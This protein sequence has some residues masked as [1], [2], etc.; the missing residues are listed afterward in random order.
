MI[1]YEAEAWETG[2]R[3][4]DE[5]GYDS[6]PHSRYGGNNPVQSEESRHTYHQASHAGDYYRDTN[7]TYNNNSNPNLRLGPRSQASHSNLSH[8]S[9]LLP[10]QT[11]SQ[12]GAGGGIMPPQLP[13]MP[14]GAGGPPSLP[15]SD[16]GGMAAMSMMPTLGYQGTGSMHGM[17]MGMNMGMMGGGGGG[18]S[19]HGSQVG[20]YGGAPQQ[21]NP[22]AGS[23]MQRPTSTFSFATS[24]NP[25]AGPNMSENP[26]DEELFQALRNYL[27]TQDLMSV[28]KK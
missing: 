16:Y 6:K 17:P 11:M 25:F 23:A 4:S 24:V 15:G 10:G 2:S 21:M 18:G 20:G 3:R 14:F 12:F 1:E 19:V 8:Q 22:F 5:T 13:F 28:T 27:S 7:L 26:T 9:G